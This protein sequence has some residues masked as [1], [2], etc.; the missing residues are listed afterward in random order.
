V[1]VKNAGFLLQGPT[2]TQFKDAVQPLHT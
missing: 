1:Q 2:R